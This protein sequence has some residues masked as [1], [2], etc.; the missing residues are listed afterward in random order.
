MKIHLSWLFSLV[1]LIISTSLVSGAQKEDRRIWITNTTL[2]DCKPIMASSYE[3][4]RQAYDAMMFNNDRLLFKLINDKAVAELPNGQEVRVLDTRTIV[5]GSLAKL[6]NK[7]D[8]DAI[9][10]DLCLAKKAAK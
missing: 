6:D 8:V 7:S 1:I 10:V 2:R 5:F 9:W 3:V 4:F